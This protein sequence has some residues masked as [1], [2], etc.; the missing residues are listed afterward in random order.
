MEDSQIIEL[1][2]IRS[3]AA[4]SETANKYGRYCYSIAYSILQNHADAEECVND[5]WLRAWH[6]IPPARPERLAA[7][8]GKITRNLSLNKYE[9]DVAQKR[10]SGQTSLVFE[11][12]E[13]IIPANSLADQMIDD[14]AFI[15]DLNQFL[16]SLPAETRKVF[17]RRYWYFSQVNEIAVDFGMSESKVKMILF[18]ARKSLKTLLGKK[19]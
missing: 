19:E 11:E 3:E 14:R 1:F 10:G 16:A 8:L 2:W 9:A 7:F 15:D 13:N 5:T 6:A 4:I 18:R 17:M 12:L